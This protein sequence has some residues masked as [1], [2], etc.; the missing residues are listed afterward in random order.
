MARDI[1]LPN[2]LP[3]G[4]SS[5]PPSTRPPMPPAP[6]GPAVRR[7]TPTAR[8]TKGST[9]PSRPLRSPV[10]E[11]R[12]PGLARRWITTNTNALKNELSTTESSTPAPN[13]PSAPPD[14]PSSTPARMA[15]APAPA[16]MR[17]KGSNIRSRA[18]WPDTISTRTNRHEEAV[19]KAWTGT[20]DQPSA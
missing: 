17:T 20:T 9:T 11:A 13:S 3:G 7:G 12:R 4:P 16:S 15:T 8:A 6:P 10:A 19:A 1:R 5:S 18:T 2:P 14:P